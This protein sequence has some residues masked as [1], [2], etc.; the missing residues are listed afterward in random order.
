MALREAVWG[1]VFTS[2]SAFSSIRAPGLGPS[3]RS[4][5][6]QTPPDFGLFAVEAE[7]ENPLP[8]HKRGVSGPGWLP[9][10]LPHRDDPASLDLPD[11]DP[12]ENIAVL[13]EVD[14]P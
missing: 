4:Q 6:R 3:Q 13:L 2:T 9:R 7:E 12:A 5:L 10:D 11:E 14:R 1:R 8:L